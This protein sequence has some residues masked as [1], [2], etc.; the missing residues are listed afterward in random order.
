LIVPS[1]ILVPGPHII[2]GLLD[3]VDNYVP[4]GIARLALA[5]GILVAAALGITVGMEITLGEIPDARSGAS[6]PLNVVSDM[7]LAG[8]VTCGF[9]LAYNTEWSRVALAMV[10]GMIGHGLRFLALQWGCTLGAA[11]FMGG[12]AVGI[13]SAYIAR[14]TRSPFAVIAFAGAVTM[15]PGVQIYRALGGALKLA[16][17]DDAA[18]APPVEEVLG[19]A[20]Q[21]CVVAGALALGLVVGLRAVTLLA[22]RGMESGD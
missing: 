13:A 11:T 5:A 3:L 17:L 14:T 2:N 19:N 12:I 21:A 16:R 9:A 1:L 20:L 18:G 4:L 8:V 7:F 6:P 10:G 22:A 15:M